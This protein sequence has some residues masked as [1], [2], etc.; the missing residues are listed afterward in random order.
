MEEK[1]NKIVS[2]LNLKTEA[3]PKIKILKVSSSPQGKEPSQERS[4]NM[5]ANK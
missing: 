4:K 1:N 2:S 3:K 5:F